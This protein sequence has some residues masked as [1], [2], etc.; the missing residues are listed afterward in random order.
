LNIG[1]RRGTSKGVTRVTP[2]AAT[3]PEVRFR[4]AD[5]VVGEVLDGEVVLLDTKRGHY[6]R[7]NLTG[8]R[9]WSSLERDSRLSLAV[10]SLLEEF[11]VE[12]QA[13]LR[14]V[15]AVLKE[16][17]SL[18]LLI[19]EDRNDPEESKREASD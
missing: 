16:L 17:E 18:N 4:I 12:P 19:R 13:L 10:D 15:N 5:G 8:T 14:D 3:A 9:L 1:R 2:Q 7:L 6:Y 11:N